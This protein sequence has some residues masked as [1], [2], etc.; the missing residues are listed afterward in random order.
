VEVNPLATRKQTARE[1]APKESTSVSAS[2]AIGMA[3][4]KIASPTGATP[5]VPPAA[6]S[7][8]KGKLAPKH[9][10]R[11]PRRQKKA[12]QKAQALRK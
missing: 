4:G 1:E 3:D 12:Q 8:K 9:K 6:K 10:S 5:Q 2:K 11:L 7:I